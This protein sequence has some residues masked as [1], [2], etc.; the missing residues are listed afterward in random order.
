MKYAKDFVTNNGKPKGTKISRIPQGCEDTNFKSFF[1]E[2]YPAIK[3]DFGGPGNLANTH[4]DQDIS[5][6]AAQQVRA[7]QLLFEKMGDLV[8][9][10]VYVLEDLSNPVEITDPAE[11]GKFFAESN[12]IVQIKGTK[13]QYIIKWFGPKASIESAQGMNK[14][15]ETLLGGNFTSDDSSFVVKKGQEDDSFM[16][17]FP[18]GFAILDE[19]RIPMAEW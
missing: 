19:A 13:H 17:F 5:K 8:S 1:E 18:D 2:F 10:K 12:Y 4:A 11:Q 6:V 9:K 7:K 15:T 14:A 3:Q 16:S